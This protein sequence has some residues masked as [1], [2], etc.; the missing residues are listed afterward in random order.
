MECVYC[1]GD[2]REACACLVYMDDYYC[3]EECLYNAIMEDAEWVQLDEME[4]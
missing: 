4:D 3:D 1:G 2:L